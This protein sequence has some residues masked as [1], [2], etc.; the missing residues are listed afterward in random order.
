MLPSL[1]VLGLVFGIPVCLGVSVLWW[2]YVP[3]VSLYALLTAADALLEAPSLRQSA[4]FWV[5]LVA[6]HLWYGIRFIQGVFSHRMPCGVVP[7]DHR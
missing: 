4:C 7:F 2:V 6:T 3:I 1:F 5:G